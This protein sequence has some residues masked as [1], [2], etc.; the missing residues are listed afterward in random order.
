MHWIINV[1]YLDGYKLKLKFEN[2]EYKVVD[3]QSY[4]E[5]K[6][7]EPLKNISYFKSVT[8]NRDIDTVVWPNNADFSPDFLYEIS[9]PVNN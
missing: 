5:G 1:S 6:I 4:L 7:F 8:L 2:N 9:Q 3:L